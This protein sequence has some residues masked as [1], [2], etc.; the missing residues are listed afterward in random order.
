MKIALDVLGG[1]NAPLSTIEGAFSY[2]DDQGD[3]AAELILLGDKAQ[4]ESTIQELSRDKDDITIH[5]TTEIIGMNERSSR[6]FREKPD[7]SLV[8]S[9]QLVRDGEAQAAVS[10]GNTGALLASSLF[11]IGKIPGILRPAFAPYIPTD[12][13]GFILCDAGANADTKPQHLVQFALMACAYMEHLGNHPNPRV[14]LLNIGLE[15]NKGNELT[16]NTYPML[17]SHISNFIGNIESRYLLDGKADIVICDGFTGNIVL[18]LTEGIISHLMGWIQKGIESHVINKDASSIC[19]PI[20]DEIN[21]TLDHEEHG[22][23]PLLGINGVIMKCHGSTS[24]RGI[25]NSLIATQKTVQE[26]LI[27]DIVEI[28]SKHTDI[29][30]NSTKLS[31]ANPV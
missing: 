28:L 22:A 23:T 26:N 27:A 30:D 2:L 5:H 11:M 17:K 6:I 31:E 3:S 24:A 16:I 29:I 13:G 10:A 20:F 25:K 1:D 19:Q 7:S 14:A 12:N 18:K 15:E 9:I 8:K 4:I 21:T